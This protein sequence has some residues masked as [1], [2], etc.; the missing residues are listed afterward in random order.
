MLLVSSDSSGR[1]GVAEMQWTPG[2]NPTAK[3]TS[4][5]AG[6]RLARQLASEQ[7]HHMRKNND[8]EI[9]R[10]IQPDIWNTAQTTSRSFERK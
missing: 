8:R 3:M 2:F 4:F 9:P 7:L 1:K 10:V 5:H 6:D